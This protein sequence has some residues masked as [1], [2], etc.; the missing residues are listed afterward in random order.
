[1]ATTPRLRQGVTQTWLLNGAFGRAERYPEVHDKIMDNKLEGRRQREMPVTDI[2]GTD[3]AVAS[4]RNRVS[5]THHA[6]EC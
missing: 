4:E 3:G 6:L 1:M 5:D 2:N